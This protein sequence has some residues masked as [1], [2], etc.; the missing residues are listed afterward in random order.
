[1]AGLGPAIHVFPSSIE[2]V[3][4]RDKRGHDIEFGPRVP[5]GRDEKQTTA[6]SPSAA[7][8]AVAGA[9]AGPPAGSAIRLDARQAR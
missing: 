6:S 4:A 2:D 3:D 8:S 7:S 5:R 9:W 1:M